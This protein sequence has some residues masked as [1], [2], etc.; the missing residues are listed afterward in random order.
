[1]SSLTLVLGHH[2]PGTSRL[3]LKFSPG[4][5]VHGIENSPLG[6]ESSMVHPLQPS[7]D[8][9]EVRPEKL[10][11]QIENQKV[12]A[13]LPACRRLGWSFGPF[14]IEATGAW[15]GKAKHLTQLITQKY[16]LHNDCWLSVICRT[17]LQIPLLRSFVAAA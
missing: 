10:A 2:R 7:A 1:M 6:V 14:V 8:L 12:R 15:G 11:R 4:V 17:R 9:A 3:V 13:Q 16:V 5:L